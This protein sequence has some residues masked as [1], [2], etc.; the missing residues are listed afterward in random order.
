MPT[1]TVINQWRYSDAINRTFWDNK[2]FEDQFQFQPAS[3]KVGGGA[4][5]GTAGDNNV[6]VT[7]QN[8]W[9]WNVIGT[10]T[11]LAPSNDS[12][13]LN[14]VQDQTNGDGIELCLG[15]TALTPAS[16]IIGTDRAFFM[17]CEFKVQDVSGVNPLIIGF[18]KVQAFDATLSNY[19]D[20]VAL[21]IVGTAAKYQTE[22]QIGSA[23]VVTT[24]TTQTATD[25]A[26]FRLKILVSATGVV[27]YQINDVAPTVVAAYTFTNGL[28]VIPFIR[29]IEA[30]DITSESAI[31][32]FAVGYQS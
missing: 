2:Y 17:E 25:G 28:Q 11:I 20:F 10:Q 29:S 6:L 22:T 1:P 5:T 31:D 15:Q 18:R 26:I 16:Y 4:A 8:L 30:S 13:G 7:K 9:E 21:G 23:G 32:Y 14:L 12:F 19:T 27:T 3:S 24:D